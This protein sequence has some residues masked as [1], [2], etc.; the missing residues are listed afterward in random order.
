MFAC[1]RR[2]RYRRSTSS[3]RPGH[4]WGRDYRKKACT[5]QRPIPT[6][7]KINATRR[8]LPRWGH[9]AFSLQVI[10]DRYTQEDHGQCHKYGP[11]KKTPHGCSRSAIPMQEFQRW[12]ESR[13]GDPLQSMGKSP[14]AGG[15]GRGIRGE[16]GAQPLSLATQDL[17]LP[18]PRSTHS[19]ERCP[20]HLMANSNVAAARWGSQPI[21]KTCGSHS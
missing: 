6:P 14:L 5:T 3:R 15:Y 12:R 20:G 11:E 7:A 4:F 19:K 9:L 17:L 8:S 2:A 13:R 10:S 16:E 1:S 18:K 21:L